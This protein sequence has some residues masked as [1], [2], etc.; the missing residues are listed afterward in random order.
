MDWQSKI[1]ELTSVGK[2]T[3]I[4]MRKLDLQ[5]IKDLIYFFPSRYEDFSL[6]KKI[7]ELHVDQPVTI[8]GQ[9]ELIANRRS[10]RKRMI[11]TEALVSDE[12]GSVKVLWFNQPYL[13]KTLKSGD[14]IFLS[15]KPEMDRF[16][17]QFVSPQYERNNF[18]SENYNTAR[19]VPVYSLTAGVTV[20]QLRFLLKQCLPFIRSIKEYLPETIIMQNNLMP[21]NRAL[22]NI[23]FP[24]NVDL[25]DQ[26]KKRLQFD[27]L[28]II[29]LQVQRW[30]QALDRGQALKV[31][32]LEKQT[33]D[34]VAQLPFT[35]TVDQKKSAWEIIQDLQ[36]ARPMNRLLEG[37][38]GSGKTMVAALAILNV[39]L[40]GYQSVLMAPTEILAAQHYQN[41]LK[42]YLNKKIIVGLLTRTRHEVQGEK[43]TKKK[44]HDLLNQ[45]KIDLLIGTQ[46]LIQDKVKIK[47]LGLVI[48]D[49]QHRFGVKQRQLLTTRGENDLIPHFLSM[50][51]TPIPRS[52]ALALYSDLDLSIISTMPV[53]RKPIITRLVTENN[54]Q[55][56]YDFIK[57]E[58][59]NGRQVFVVCPLIDPSD[60][61]GV[62]SVKQEYE[63]LS[64]QIFPE[65]KVAL[66]HGKLKAEEKNNI[67]SDFLNKKYQILVST[68]VI[69]VGVDVPNSSIMIIEGADR[70]GLAQLHQFRGRVGRGE[71]QS[72]CFVFTDNNS[73]ATMKRLQYFVQCKN[74]FELAEKD[75]ALRG[76]GEIFGL[77]QSG[78]PEI[79]LADL[80]DVKAIKQA[81]KSARDFLINHQ[82]SAYPEIQEK[83]D[84]WD[85]IIHLE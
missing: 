77:R 68:S 19:L 55:N 71:Y 82:I 40:S 79:K 41:F 35:L 38:V 45:G 30:R 22:E 36:K 39:A 16:G 24:G 6:I 29:Q 14:R 76:S 15:G 25:L 2:T 3:A 59:N 63:K 64:E 53:G 69:E 18:D 80:S 31:N 37:D 65:F 13:T 1:S 72:Y 52:L 60:K 12:S 34:F 23:H 48:V 28:F 85:K 67:M 20:K 74:G 70:F 57:Q 27:E 54:R 44:I 9:I 78:L 49:E 73:M 51:A 26:A 47:D 58:I 7:S 84:S 8:E 62:K 43:V 50:T 11:L 21:F 33:Q 42:L 75:L 83:L 4:K 32:F 66:L 17:I 56:A 10:F 81:Q 61:L 46:A 5:T